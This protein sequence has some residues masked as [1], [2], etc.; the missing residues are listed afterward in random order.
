[1]RVRKA[2]ISGPKLRPKRVKFDGFA[3]NS[4]CPT[5]LPRPDFWYASARIAC[6]R[7]KHRRSR[8]DEN[9]TVPALGG[10]QAPIHYPHCVATIVR[11]SVV[12]ASDDTPGPAGLMIRLLPEIAKT[13]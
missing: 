3:V 9:I 4:S 5:S 10:H 2:Y 8:R 1:M 11:F 6:R 7:R 13:P 12:S